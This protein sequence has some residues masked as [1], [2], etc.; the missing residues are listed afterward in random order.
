MVNCNFVLNRLT[1]GRWFSIDMR[2]FPLE[3]EQETGDWIEAKL[4]EPSKQ[5]SA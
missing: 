5:A 2:H 1:R 4:V 3:R